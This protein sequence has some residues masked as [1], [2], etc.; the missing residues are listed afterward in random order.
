MD[1]KKMRRPLCIPVDLLAKLKYL[2]VHS[3][4]RGIGVV[5]PHLLQEFV[6][7]NY[8]TGVINEI[9]QYFDF[10]CRKRYLHSVSIDLCSSEVDNDA[11]EPGDGSALICAHY[12]LCCRA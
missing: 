11:S 10:M 5:A 12:A 8:A 2:V 9:S 4:G 3:A 1:S 7:G 6:S